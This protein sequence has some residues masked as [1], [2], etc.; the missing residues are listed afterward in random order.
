M[1][2][3]IKVA[4][5]ALLIVVLGA[6]GFM[7]SKVK[8]DKIAENVIVNGINLGGMTKEEAKNK[9]KVFDTN[10][11]TLSSEERSWKLNLD[12]LN[13]EYDISK[14]VENAYKVDRSGNIFSNMFDMAKSMMGHETN[15][16]VAI[17][18][19]K[20]KAKEE[21]DKIRKDVDREKENAKINTDNDKITI[22][23]EKN[24]VV[25]NE[26]ETNK[27]IEK[28]LSANKFKTEAV[29][30]LDEPKIKK[31]D[32]E[33]MDKALGT[34]VTTFKNNY[35]RTE[36]IKI[37]TNASSGVIL[38]P[39]QEYSF[40]TIVGKR[41]KANGYKS[42][43]VIV[44]GEMQEDLGGGVCQVSSTLYNAALKSGMKIVNV[45]NHTIPSSY[46]G[47]GRD[48]TVTDSGIDFVFKNPYKHNVYIQ[49]YV[50]GGSIV[51]QV[52]GSKVDEQNI[53]I[54]TKTISVSQAT[55]QKVE[56]SDLPAGKEEVDKASRNGYVVETYRIYKDKN[57]KQIKK[58]K[59]ATSSYPKQNGVI[60]VGTAPV[61]EKP[62]EPQ[63]PG[64]N[65]S[66][67]NGGGETQKPD[68]NAGNTGN[69][70]GEAQ[71]PEATPK[72]VKE[73]NKN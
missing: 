41:N 28:R 61:E 2:K 50:T 7:F 17:E 63:N 6:V 5:I 34:S 70:G 39:G 65:N 59:I 42:A 56:K 22:V 47:M 69:S 15:V 72:E 25:L 10:E 29:V 35:N 8:S 67:N 53:E 58:E 48:A 26:A 21:L 46:V 66:G 30:K 57:G 16:R 9:I 32:L 44:Q 4:L 55:P 60:F 71:K 18:Y 36:N 49:N 54:Q 13:F 38:K 62:E 27:A 64:E 3:K 51:C 43:P 68:G 45:K 12:E 20:A 14:T 23:P 24:G 19:D 33:G 73:N 31:S 52:F 1:S 11:F 37:A 40:N